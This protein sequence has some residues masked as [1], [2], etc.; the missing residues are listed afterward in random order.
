M[1]GRAGSAEII[2]Q[3]VD[4]STDE[5]LASQS[6]Y[7]EIAAGT[8]SEAVSFD[9][10]EFSHRLSGDT[11]TLQARIIIFGDEDSPIQQGS[12]LSD[13]VTL[14]N[15]DIALAL[16]EIEPVQQAGKDLVG[17]TGSALCNDEE[18]EGIELSF[19]DGENWYTLDEQSDGLNSGQMKSWSQQ[20]SLPVGGYGVHARLVN[21]MGLELARSQQVI[22]EVE[23]QSVLVTITHTV[24]FNSVGGSAAASIQ[25]NSGTTL[26]SRLPTSIRTGYRFDGWFLPN[27]TKVSATTIINSDVILTGR[28]TVTSAMLK[29]L[30]V[31]GGKFS[32][33]FADGVA[34]YTVTIPKKRAST[35]VSAV[36]QNKAA[37]VEFKIGGK[38]K[39]V[40]KQKVSLKLGKK[41]TV[42]IRVK[43]KG[44]KTMTYK[45]KVARAKK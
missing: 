22:F 20:V 18:L 1:A 35:T 19:D 40:N 24:T 34:S 21:S 27:G 32:K 17:I 10:R 4:V 8:A 12:A 44:L 25:I 45:V 3:I 31:T 16:I 42:T 11:L 15:N 30:K 6:V 13:P 2:A 36:K 28:W 9:V 39:K 41:V 43:Q 5:I 33:P 29:S 23:P 7:T 14:N 38:W 26:G 37:T